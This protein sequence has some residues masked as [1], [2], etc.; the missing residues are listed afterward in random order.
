MGIQSYLN[1]MIIRT[2]YVSNIN[3]VCVQ[4]FDSLFHTPPRANYN[5]VCSP[6]S[7]IHLLRQVQLIGKS[8]EL[9]FGN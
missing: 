1:I 6:C 7:I 8:G 4:L 9:N 2:L 5:S 3:T